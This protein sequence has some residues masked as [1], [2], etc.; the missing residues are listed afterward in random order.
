ML[1]AMLWKWGRAQW[2]LSSLAL[3]QCLTGQVPQVGLRPTEQGK[4][5]RVKMCRHTC[6]WVSTL[7]FESVFASGGI[8][9]AH[10][11]DFENVIVSE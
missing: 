8:C 5:V 1:G 4:C 9:N 6:E 3:Q 7:M 10:A 11:L 2:G